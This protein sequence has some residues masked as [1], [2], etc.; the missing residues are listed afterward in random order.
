MTETTADTKAAPN[1]LLLQGFGS[2]ASAAARHDRDPSFAQ[3]RPHLITP[4]I[5]VSFMV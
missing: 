1:R 3:S 5:R 4:V 2:D